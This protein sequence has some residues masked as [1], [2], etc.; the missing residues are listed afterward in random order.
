M[1][2]GPTPEPAQ[3]TTRTTCPSPSTHHVSEERCVI[4]RIAWRPDI[5]RHDT[6]TLC[7]SIMRSQTCKKIGIVHRTAQSP[8]ELAAEKS[9]SM[10]YLHNRPEERCGDGSQQGLGE[11]R[12]WQDA[13][14]GNG[15]TIR[16]KINTDPT[17]FP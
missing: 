9:S 6:Q 14:P 15:G 2:R 16:A 8:T 17:V 1:P 12:T 7:S 4:I 11:G 3:H 10:Q 5:N 13:V